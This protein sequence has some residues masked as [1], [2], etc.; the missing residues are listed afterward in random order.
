MTAPSA[1]T[2][3]AREGRALADR[4]LSRALSTLGTDSRKQRGDL[5]L[6]S[7]LLRFLLRDFNDRELIELDLGPG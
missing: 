3:T 6:A 5:K 2:V 7:K 1:I 4:L